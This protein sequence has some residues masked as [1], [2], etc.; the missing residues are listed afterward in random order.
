SLL[1]YGHF[2]CLLYRGKVKDLLDA[3][4]LNYF[5]NSSTAKEYGKTVVISSVN[6]ANINGKKLQS[7][8]I[9][10][11]PLAEQR[12]IV[13]RLDVLSAETKKLEGIYQSKLEGLEEL[14]RSVLARAFEG[15]I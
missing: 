3:D 15:E 1:D 2:W 7:Y 10:L 4:Y 8:P 14:K 6:Q 12:A 11:P 13:A 5:L 9:P